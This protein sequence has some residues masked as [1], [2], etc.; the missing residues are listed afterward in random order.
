MFPGPDVPLAP[1]RYVAESEDAVSEYV[2]PTRILVV[3]DHDDTRR[4]FQDVLV[5]AGF[6]VYTATHGAEA[7]R[8]LRTEVADAIILDLMLPWINGI[9]VLATLREDPRL[10][11]IPVVVTTATATSDMDLRAYRPLV[12]MRKPFNLEALA[13]T[14]EQLLSAP[15]GSARRRSGAAGDT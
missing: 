12:V 2:R 4:M 5:Q 13:P 7:L 15:S 3:E 6:E 14:V 8:F 9:E 1:L 11:Q 10:A